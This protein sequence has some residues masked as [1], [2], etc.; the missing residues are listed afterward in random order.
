MTRC[1]AC[2]RGRGE[3]EPLRR[4]LLRCRPAGGLARSTAG[5]EHGCLPDLEPW[6]RPESS[7]GSQRR[8]CESGPWQPRRPRPVPVPVPPKGRLRGV[9]LGCGA[10]SECSREPRARPPASGSPTCRP[11]VPGSV[12]QPRQRRAR[13][14]SARGVPSAQTWRRAGRSDLTW[15]GGWYEAPSSRRD[16]GRRWPSWSGQPAACAVPPEVG[17]RGCGAWRPQAP[18]TAG[19]APRRPAWSSG[20]FRTLPHQRHLSHRRWVFPKLSA[21]GNKMEH[22]N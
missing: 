13:R 9:R 16:G 4:G 17:E 12:A 10:R 5:S 18:P 20:A 15:S 11:P 19:P 7:Q 8:A 1:S 6:T 2:R 14:P 3:P 22:H 21:T